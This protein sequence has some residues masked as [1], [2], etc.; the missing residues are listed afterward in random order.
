MLK[1][2]GEKKKITRRFSI[3]RG[4]I[5]KREIRVNQTV[6]NLNQSQNASPDYVNRPAYYL[7][8]LYECYKYMSLGIYTAQVN[9][10]I[11]YGV[12]WISP[13][14]ASYNKDE[15]IYSSVKR[16]RWMAKGT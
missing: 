1:C 16:V 10:S 6:P 7:C 2:S 9:C 5:I 13:P 4:N 11:Q 12:G 3:F 15:E 14:A 8:V